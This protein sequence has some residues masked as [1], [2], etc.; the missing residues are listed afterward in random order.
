MCAYYV[1]IRFR[2]QTDNPFSGEQARNQ[3]ATLIN[4]MNTHSDEFK[5]VDP[6]NDYHY[7]MIVSTSVD[8]KISRFYGLKIAPNPNDTVFA[9]PSE[10]KTKIQK[11]LLKI[12]GISDTLRTWANEQVQ[13]A[14]V[15]QGQDIDEAVEDGQ[16]EN[17]QGAVVEDNGLGDYGDNYFVPIIPSKMVYSKSS[18]S[19][20]TYD[21]STDRCI[22]FDE[23]QKITCNLARSR[24]T[25]EHDRD[26]NVIR[27][28]EEKRK[29]LI[30]EISSYREV[31]SIGAIM[32]ETDLTDMNI[33]Q[34]EQCRDQCK[35]HFEHF[36]TMEVF[37]QGSTVIGTIYDAVF[38]NGIPISKKKKIRLEGVGTELNELLFN[39]RST[40]GK[41]FSDILSKYRIGI[42]NEALLGIVILS[43]IMKK[44][45]IE[46]RSDDEDADEE[47]EEE[48]EEEEEDE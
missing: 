17:N 25:V 48:A 34:L 38:P 12:P 20:T 43:S 5:D 6:L 22:T 29:E 11:T 33:Q 2:Y 40:T 39:T 23:L 19:L 31:K 15:E 41:A 44:V 27:M 4:Y 7:A 9:L 10:L 3:R 28:E 8:N 13:P 35:R 24:L 16:D 45:K 18:F 21:A 46:D 1:D 37:K 36:K 32:N 30:R 14:A 42:S 26:E 47:E